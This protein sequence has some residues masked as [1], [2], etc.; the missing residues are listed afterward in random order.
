MASFFPSDNPAQWSG[1][2]AASG[3]FT[4]PV[5]AWNY[6]ITSQGKSDQGLSISVCYTQGVGSLFHKWGLGRR[7]LQSLSHTCLGL[8]LNI[9]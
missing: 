5:L 1:W 7:E 8:S 4:L 6:H 3:V 9:R 2:A